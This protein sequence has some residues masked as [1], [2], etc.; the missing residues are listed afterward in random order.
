MVAIDVG[1]LRVKTALLSPADPTGSL[2][3]LSAV[4]ALPTR[5]PEILPRLLDWLRQQGVEQC[6]AVMAGSHPG[7]CQTIQESWPAAC[8]APPRWFRTAPELPLGLDVDFPARLGVD[9]ALN[10]LAAR[11]IVGPRDAAIVVD[12]G[13][14]TTIDLVNHEGRFQGGAIL[15][16]FELCAYALHH[17]TALLPLV[18]LDDID[19]GPPAAI[20][21]STEP[22]LRSGLLWGHVGAVERLVDEIVRESTGPAPRLILTGGAAPRLQPH[23]DPRFQLVPYL[24]LRGL[25]MLADEATN[26]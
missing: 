12:S 19:Q 3:E 17:Y 4:L 25:G 5:G 7:V 1:N 14:A 15:P 2:P 10:A 21:K 11:A 13:T 26:A 20:G 9:R 24:A 23:L 16:G 18:Q 22:A 6:R 8:G